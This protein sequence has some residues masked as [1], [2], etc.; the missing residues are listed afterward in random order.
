MILYHGS[1]KIIELSKVY[2]RLGG[3]WQEKITITCFLHVV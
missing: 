3:I 1:N 2:R